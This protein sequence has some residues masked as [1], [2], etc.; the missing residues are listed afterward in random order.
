M[1]LIQLLLQQCEVRKYKN[2]TQHVPDFPHITC[3]VITHICDYGDKNLFREILFPTLHLYPC[4][5]IAFCAYT[6]PQIPVNLSQEC[7]RPLSCKY[8]YLSFRGADF[9]EG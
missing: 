4:L 8:V 9:L 5:N 3:E 1:T 2:K 6:L 7:Q